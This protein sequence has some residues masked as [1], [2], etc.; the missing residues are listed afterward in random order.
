M[1]PPEAL[2]QKYEHIVQT[3]E[4]LIEAYKKKMAG[5]YARLLKELKLV[6][7]DAYEDYADE[8][9]LSFSEMQR[10]DR[11][12][13]LQATLDRVTDEGTRP[14]Y[15]KMEAGLGE[16]ASNTYA[17]SIAAINAVTNSNM[18]PE[19]S[20]GQ[21]QEIL[22]KPWSGI[23]LQERI[24]LRR[25]DIGTRIR[26]SVIRGT[27]QEASYEDQARALKEEI[28]KDLARTGR[29]MEDTGHQVQNDTIVSSF[30]DAKEEEIEIT[31][32]WVSAGDERV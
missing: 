23:T 16:V 7:A 30:K 31:K 22:N 21:I 20:S 32:T 12:R 26:Q 25:T 27:I 5:D 4:K 17:G 11:I 2:Y 8:G 18:G 9:K 13:R 15:A 28:V 3:N 29:M 19:L 14:L 24:G 6:V 1:A 10:F